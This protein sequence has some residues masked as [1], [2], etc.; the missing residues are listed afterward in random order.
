MPVL[1]AACQEEARPGVESTADTGV[2]YHG[3]RKRRDGGYQ[4]MAGWLWCRIGS[5]RLSVLS[6]RVVHRDADNDGPRP[7]GVLFSEARYPVLAAAGTDLARVSG[8][9]FHARGRAP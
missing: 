9:T 4:A 6:G 7:Q 1:R 2:P 3:C 8:W 5:P